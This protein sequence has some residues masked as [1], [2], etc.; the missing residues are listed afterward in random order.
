MER[1][2][3]L[4]LASIESLFVLFCWWPLDL[5]NWRRLASLRSSLLVSTSKTF[6]IHRSHTP[7]T[8][9]S[10]SL[11][12]TA[13]NRIYKDNS[14]GLTDSVRWRLE[15]LDVINWPDGY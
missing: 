13:T 8:T 6:G 3:L 2:V 15:R 4:K 1:T 10:S 14:S 9:I 12:L 11:L 7:N 5:L